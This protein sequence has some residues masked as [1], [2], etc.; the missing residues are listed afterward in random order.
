MLS[1]SRNQGS[2]NSRSTT[3]PEMTDGQRRCSQQ[4]TDSGRR[5]PTESPGSEERCCG[6][7]THAGWGAHHRHLPVWAVFFWGAYS[8]STARASLG[9]STSNPLVLSQDNY[10]YHS[11][12]ASVSVFTLTLQL[13]TSSLLASCLRE[14]LKRKKKNLSRKRDLPDSPCCHRSTL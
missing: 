4:A 3:S 11:N 14:S 8:V 9:R 10:S 5:K 2:P 13:N 7:V 6:P 1:R 12:T